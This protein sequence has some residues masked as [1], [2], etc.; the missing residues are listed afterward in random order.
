MGAT[1]SRFEGRVSVFWQ[2]KHA[3]QSELKRAVSWGGGSV[4]WKP[5]H[6]DWSELKRVVSWRTEC[7]LAT[8]ICCINEWK[9]IKNCVPQCHNK[10]KQYLHLKTLSR[11]SFPTHSVSGLPRDASTSFTLPQAAP[12]IFR[13]NTAACGCGE[14]WSAGEVLSHLPKSVA[15]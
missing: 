3:D 15:E 13:I 8:K 14:T 5:K 12:T 9:I 10:H 2:P 11:R 7:I 1:H 4:F 6:A